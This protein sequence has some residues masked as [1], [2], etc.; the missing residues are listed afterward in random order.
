MSRKS[1]CQKPAV[2]PF[3]VVSAAGPS[4]ILVLSPKA[5]QLVKDALE[6]ISPDED[7]AILTAQAIALDLEG[8]LS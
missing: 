4:I 8:V 5:A 2:Y 6:I 3:T 1:Q 7:D